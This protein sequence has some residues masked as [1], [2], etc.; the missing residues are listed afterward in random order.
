MLIEYPALAD[1][2]SRTLGATLRRVLDQAADLIFLD[3]PGRVAKLL[4]TLAEERSTGA[5]RD[6]VLDLHVTQGTIAGMVGGSRSSV[7]Q[8]LR[9]FEARGLLEVD[10]RKIILKKEDA[11]RRRAAAY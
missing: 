6:R 8:I 10:G 7:N 11:L 4:I 1:S 2:L 9:G 5:D 3:L